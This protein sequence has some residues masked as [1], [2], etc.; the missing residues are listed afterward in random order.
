MSTKMNI[1]LI[2]GIKE[3]YLSEEHEVT[4]GSGCVNYAV[5]GHE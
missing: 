1:C 3:S 5:N 4:W 2:K